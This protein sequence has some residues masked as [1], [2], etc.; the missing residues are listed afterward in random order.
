MSWGKK[1]CFSALSPEEFHLSRPFILGDYN[2]YARERS[3]SIPKVRT[4]FPLGFARD[5]SPYKF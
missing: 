2:S 5:H 3:V 1:N 4:A